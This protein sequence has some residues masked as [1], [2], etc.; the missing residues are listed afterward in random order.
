MRKDLGTNGTDLT[1]LDEFIN[2]V[3]VIRVLLEEFSDLLDGHLGRDPESVNW[4]D[5]GDAGYCIDK[6]TEILDRVNGGRCAL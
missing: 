1:A 3:G 2:R 6:L 5:V 4:G